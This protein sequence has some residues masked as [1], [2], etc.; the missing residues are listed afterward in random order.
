LVSTNTQN[1]PFTSS[2]T[3][4][5]TTI[6]GLGLAPG[7]YKWTWGSG[8]NADDIKVVIPSATPEPGSLALLGMG[9]AGMVAYGW[10]RRKHSI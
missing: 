8:A 7:T 2:A 6:S 3:W 5:G 10:R 9:V 1:L 4:A